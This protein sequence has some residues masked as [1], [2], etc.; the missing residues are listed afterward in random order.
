MYGAQDI[1]SKGLTVGIGPPEGLNFGLVQVECREKEA[2]R[3][4]KSF[5]IRL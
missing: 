5:V 2:A 3:V 1:R 4:I